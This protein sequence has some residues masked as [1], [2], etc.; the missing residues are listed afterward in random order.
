MHRALDWYD[1]GRRFY[2]PAGVH[3]TT[4]DPLAES[5]NF[6]SPYVYAANNPV[7][8]IDNNGEGPIAFGFIEIRVQIPILETMLGLAA[9]VN[10]TAYLDAENGELGLSY[11]NY[12]LGFGVGGGLALSI[13][14]GLSFAQNLDELEGSGYNIGLSMSEGFNIGGFEFN[15]SAYKGLSNLHKASRK[16][17]N[18]SPPGAGVGGIMAFYAELSKTHKILRFGSV[19]DIVDHIF[20][21]YNKNLKKSIGANEW[22]VISQLFNLDYDMIKLEYFISKDKLREEIEKILLN[23]NSNNNVE[24]MRKKE[25]IKKFNN[26]TNLQEGVYKWDG[27]DWVH[28]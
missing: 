3:F 22:F 11:G 1:Y 28:Q 15:W 10:A 12:S 20:E 9:S 23:H 26:T 6:Q 25:K 14:S 8:F 4:M 5:F 24:S 13:G 21:E 7:Y 19:S 27:N 17:G 2:D 16:G 18:F